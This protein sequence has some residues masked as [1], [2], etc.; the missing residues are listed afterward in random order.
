MLFISI[1]I[2]S[3]LLIQP[4]ADQKHSCGDLS[5]LSVFAFEIY[6]NAKDAID[7]MKDRNG[8]NPSLPGLC[9]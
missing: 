4:E 3:I 5:K 9:G 6:G 8:H 2:P 7:A 1:F